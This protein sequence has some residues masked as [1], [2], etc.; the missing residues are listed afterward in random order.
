MRGARCLTRR[1]VNKTGV[2]PAWCGESKRVSQ[3]ISRGRATIA[4]DAP[5]SNFILWTCFNETIDFEDY[6]KNTSCGNDAVWGGVVLGRGRYQDD[7]R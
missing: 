5:T 6:A 1:G 4:V 7:E 3:V 2:N